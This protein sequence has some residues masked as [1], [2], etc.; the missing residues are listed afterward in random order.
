MNPR[1]RTAINIAIIGL[2]ASLVVVF[3]RPLLEIVTGLSAFVIC[4]FFLPAV[5]G[6][7][8][9]FVM[10]VWG[11]VYLRAWHIRRIRNARYMREAIERGRSD[12]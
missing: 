10:S 12:G 1:A 7:L 2:A 5:F 3:F 9:W 8:G 6:V 4:V 11:R